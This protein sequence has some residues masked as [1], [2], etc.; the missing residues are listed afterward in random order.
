MESKRIVS[1]V[2][3][4]LA[5]LLA[6]V[7]YVS[8]ALADEPQAQQEELSV[9][10]MQEREEF[11]RG[12]AQT[13][14]AIIQHQKQ[15]FKQRKETLRTAFAKSVDI[16]WIAR[17]V[18][19][20]SWNVA[21]EAQKERYMDLYRR[22]LTETYVANFAEKPEKRIRDIKIYGV[23]EAVEPEDFNVRTLMMLANSE[24]LQ[25]NYLVN[26]QDGKYKVRDIAIEN[27]SLITTH[28]AEFRE[29]ATIRGVD[30]VLDELNK[31]VQRMQAPIELS[32]K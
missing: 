30:G 22:Y 2:L 28:R 14:L 9:S 24:D 21:S 7:G 1:I 11:A 3:M 32:M 13:V 12:F 31:R 18:L 6:E 27:I 17:F 5:L 29:M 23:T 16:D 25:V 10:S 8:V 19:G 26:E 15:S 20:K 4:L